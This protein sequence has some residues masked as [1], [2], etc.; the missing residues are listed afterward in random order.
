MRFE[1]VVHRQQHVAGAGEGLADAFLQ[2]LDAP[3]LPQ[4][5][6][7]AAGAEVGDARCSSCA[8][9]ARPWPTAW[10]WRGHRAR[11]ARSGRRPF[12]AARERSSLMMASAGIS[13]IVVWIHGPWKFSSYWPSRLA[14][15]VFGQPEIRPARRGIPA[16]RSACGRRNCC[17]PARSSPSWR[18]ARCGHG[19]AARAVRPRRSLGEPHRWR[20]G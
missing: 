12:I 4:E 5:A 20:C 15:L 11:R 17:R 10:P 1:I 7:A 14:Q 8:A 9:A 3:A 13:H 6:V 2:R 19:R 18:S 16:R